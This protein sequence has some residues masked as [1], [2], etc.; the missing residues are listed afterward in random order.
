MRLRR[1]PSEQ[2]HTKTGRRVE[3]DHAGALWRAHRVRSR[4]YR[5]DKRRSFDA[6]V[7]RDQLIVG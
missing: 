3:R 6:V 4:I 5:F 1:R 7:A 2:S